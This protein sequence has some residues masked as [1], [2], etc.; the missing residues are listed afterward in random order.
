MTLW[1]VLNLS[2]QLLGSYILYTL[3]KVI[4]QK[5]ALACHGVI[6]ILF[7]DVIAYLC[8]QLQ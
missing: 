5:A 4:V 1:H 7:V 8:K 3:K 6:I 2:E